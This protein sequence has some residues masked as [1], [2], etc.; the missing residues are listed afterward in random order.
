MQT[1][2]EEIKPADLLKYQSEYREKSKTKCFLLEFSDY[3]DNDAR[4]ENND[5]L[6]E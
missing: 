2:I 6:F 4:D 1:L 3:Q 5:F